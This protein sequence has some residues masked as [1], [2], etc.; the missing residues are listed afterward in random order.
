M[1]DAPTDVLDELPLSAPAASPAASLAAEQRDV[2]RSRILRAARSVLAA[3]GLDTTVDDVAAAADVSRRT[4][5]RHFETRDRLLAE[6]VRDALR[7][8]G[9]QLAAVSDSAASATWLLE[10][11]TAAHRMNA[12]NGRI[13]WELAALGSDV[14]GELAEVAADR[15]AARRRFAARVTT[16]AWTMRGGSG[17]PPAWLVD[18]FAVHLSAFT[19]QALAGDFGRTPDEVAKVSAGVLEASLTAALAAAAG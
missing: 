9:Q 11:L 8:Y 5:F 7:S 14:E 2:A 17:R 4:V 12:H 15:R 18:A 19:T 6:A 10:L 3:R 13:Y 16:K 1:T